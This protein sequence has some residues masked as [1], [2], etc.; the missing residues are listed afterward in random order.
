MFV[1]SAAEAALSA[2]KCFDGQFHFVEAQHGAA[3]EAK[4]ELLMA[5]RQTSHARLKN[6]K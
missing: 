1:I 2:T 6:K 3:T 4:P 5:Y